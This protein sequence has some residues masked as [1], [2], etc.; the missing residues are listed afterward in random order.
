MPF[1]ICDLLPIGQP[2]VQPQGLQTNF[3]IIYRVQLQMRPTSAAGVGMAGNG[4]LYSSSS[5]LLSAVVAER[6]VCAQGLAVM[7]P[8][9]SKS[10]ARSLIVL[11]SG[12]TGMT[13][14][15]LC[16]LYAPEVIVYLAVPR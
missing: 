6:M 2:G 3:C 7:E 13:C 8:T 5:S 11:R 10:P 9:S 15:T 4:N 12:T 16:E 1:L 14:W